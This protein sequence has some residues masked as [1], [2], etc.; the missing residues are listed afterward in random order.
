M[1]KQELDLKGAVRTIED[2]PSPGIQFKD[3]TPILG[4]PKLLRRA[5]DE[6]VEPLV[7]EGITKVV[8]IES[9]GFILG[10]GVAHALGAG[11][12]PVRKEGKLPY[13]TVR[14]EYELEYGTDVI[15]M[16][17]DA[18]TPGDVV[19]IHDDVIATGGTASACARLVT[20][21]GGELKAFSFLVELTFLKGRE[22]L[23]SG[24]DAYSVL[25]F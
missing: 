25:K 17:E 12:V 3:I 16:H 7:G 20:R 22:R 1:N 18:I 5:V 24:I 2:F 9:R 21:C 14:E 19:L 15:E 23:P 6:L 8:G 4:N 11:F 13:R 10:S